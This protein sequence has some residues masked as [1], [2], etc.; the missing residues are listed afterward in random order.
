MHS[1]MG[2]GPGQ[3]KLGRQL[4]IVLFPFGC[5]VTPRPRAPPRPLAICGRL[6]NGRLRGPG[7]SRSCFSPA[8]T[9]KLSWTSLWRCAIK[10]PVQISCRCPAE[11]ATGGEV[12]PALHD[13]DA[14]TLLQ[15]SLSPTRHTHTH[16]TDPAIHNPLHSSA[17]HRRPRPQ[18]LSMPCPLSALPRQQQVVPSLIAERARI[19]LAPSIELLRAGDKFGWCSRSHRHPN[20]PSLLAVRNGG[21]YKSRG[22]ANT[23]LLH[24][25]VFFSVISRGW[26]PPVE[27]T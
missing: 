4:G 17:R 3:S 14:A 24:V 23:R 12:R 1:D 8:S 5:V 2:V 6:Q 13:A 15:P 22:V 7:P 25:G 11:S 16:P 10:R 21:L 20:H 18:K 26:P 9:N 19:M 27:L